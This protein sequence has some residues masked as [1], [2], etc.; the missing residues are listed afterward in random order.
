MVEGSCLCGNI[1][2]EVE[3]ILEKY[4]IAIVNFV[5]RPMALTRIPSLELAYP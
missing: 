5:E 3:M 4:L 2:Y 1:R